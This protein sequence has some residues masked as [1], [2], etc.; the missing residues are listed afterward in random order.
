[1]YTFTKNS[2]DQKAK[3]HYVNHCRIL[4]KW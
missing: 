4:K 2:S 3:A 1:L